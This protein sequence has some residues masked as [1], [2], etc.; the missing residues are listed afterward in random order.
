MWDI[1]FIKII[2]CIK[3][4]NSVNNIDQKFFSWGYFVGFNSYDFK[5]NYNED[6]KDILV[7]DSF[8]FHLGLIGDMRINDHLN[9]RL[10][11]GVFFTTRTFTLYIHLTVIFL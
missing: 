9:L 5:F 8:G 6:L 7:D 4:A 2:N 1:V 10:E 3:V 11:P